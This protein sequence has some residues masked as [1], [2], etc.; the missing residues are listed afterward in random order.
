MNTL[1]SIFISPMILSGIVAFVLTPLVLFVYRLFGYVDDPKKNKHVKVT[2]KTAV[3]RGG[4]LV[5]FF[6]ILF[7]SAVFL[8]FDKHSVG[9]ILGAALLAVTGVLDD[10]YDLSPYLRIFL[11]LAAALIV[12]ASGIGIAFVTNP[13]GGI[14]NLSTPQIAFELFGKTRTIWVL[15][16]LFAVVWILW[17]MNMVNWA[18]GLDGQLPGIVVV[19]AFV[20]GLLSLRFTGDVTQWNVTV[21]AALTAGAYLGFLPWN[22]YPQ[23]I[24]PGYGGG[25]IAGYMLAVLSILSGSKLATMMIVLGVPMMDAVY[26]IIRRLAHGKSPVWGDRGHLHHKLLDLGWGKRRVA[27]FYWI[28]TA[29]LGTAAL[30]LNSRQKLFTIVLLVLGVGGL[31]L[32]LNYFMTYSK[33]P[34]QDSG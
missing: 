25:A 6:A 11:G 20:V 14:I 2:H 17:S 26:T 10:I 5:V 21:L 18:K 1:L 19:A 31:L 7:S 12:V 34:D 4:G 28:A 29:I 24:M 16:D 15:A 30:Q 8:G 27:V 9:I 22:F 13:F 33:Q 23:K 32:W 3:P